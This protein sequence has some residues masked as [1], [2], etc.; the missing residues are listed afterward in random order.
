MYETT[1]PSIVPLKEAGQTTE[2]PGKINYITVHYSRMPR[3]NTFMRFIRA[4]L[5]QS[6]NIETWDVVLICSMDQVKVTNISPDGEKK[7][8]DDPSV[9]YS[10]LAKQTKQ[11]RERSGV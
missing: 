10:V 3:L 5:C 7:L 11:G 8:K 1:H 6:F 4:G 2:E 9:V